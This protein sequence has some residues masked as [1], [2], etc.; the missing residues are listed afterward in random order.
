MPLTSNSIQLYSKDKGG[1]WPDENQLLVLKSG[2]LEPAKALNAWTQ[3]LKN[4]NITQDLLED[5]ELLP[6]IFDPI[7]EAS[8]QLLPLVH[9]NLENLEEPFS[10]RLKGYYRFKWVRAQQLLARAAQVCDLLEGAGIPTM[11]INAT[12]LSL[13]YYDEKGT[14]STYTFA[15]L[16]PFEHRY[17][18][19]SLLSES[20]LHYQVQR[21]N[22][23]G[24]RLTCEDKPECDLQW[25]LFYEHTYA[26]ADSLFWKDAVPGIVGEATITRRLSP[27]HQFFHSLLQG[28]RWNI[29]AP[30][31]WIPDCMMIARQHPIDWPMIFTLAEQF[32]YVSFIQKALPFL[33][34]EFQLD[35]SEE[36]LQKLKGLHV[37]P[38]DAYYFRSTSKA[39]KFG[40]L[41]TYIW[42]NY[43][44]YNCFIKHQRST[45]AS[46]PVWMVRKIIQRLSA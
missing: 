23:Q 1:W 5:S 38:Q 41:L 4:R 6:K 20:A 9:R 42:R 17:K 25:N 7:D 30:L 43:A 31:G 40:R 24:A 45:S 14:R 10:K 26:G 44:L 15:V 35:I 46:F 8:R 22:A 18:A 33:K 29:P 11:L 12:A 39:P 27:A 19:L 28:N 36:N 34:N 3:W 21:R 2:L 37:S 13:W 32:Q 16:V